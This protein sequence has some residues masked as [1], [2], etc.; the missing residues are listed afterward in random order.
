[1]SLLFF[2]TVYDISTYDASIGVQSQI[3]LIIFLH[4]SLLLAGREGESE[5]QKEST[6]LGGQF[7]ADV[8]QSAPEQALSRNMLQVCCILQHNFDFFAIAQIICLP[9]PC[10]C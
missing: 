2:C 3:R 8:A 6:L 5:R 9:C 10:F 4:K 1:M 7:V